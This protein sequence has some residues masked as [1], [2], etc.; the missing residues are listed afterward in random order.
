MADESVRQSGQRSEWSCGKRAALHDPLRTADVQVTLLYLG[1]IFCSQFIILYNY[2]IKMSST[3]IWALWE[4]FSAAAADIW[5]LAAGKCN[6]VII[7]YF[8]LNKMGIFPWLLPQGEAQS[9]AVCEAILKK[10]MSRISRH[11]CLLRASFKADC[12]VWQCVRFLLSFCLSGCFILGRW[13]D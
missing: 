9:K 11:D 10:Y 2:Y 1:Q 12:P 13:L 8:W 3:I 7:S 4:S 6:Y 5:C